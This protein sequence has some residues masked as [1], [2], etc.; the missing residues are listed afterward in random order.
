MYYRQDGKVIQGDDIENYENKEDC[1]CVPKM[2]GLCVLY[3][4]LFFTIVLPL[5][6][7]NTLTFI[8]ET[9]ERKSAYMAI[10]V[11][12]IVFIII[13]NCI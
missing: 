13:L 1:G 9:T 11:L 5:F 12:L 3:A 6:H 4:L 10:I 7:R 2:I 8:F